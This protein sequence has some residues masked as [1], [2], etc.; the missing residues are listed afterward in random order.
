MMV[1][2]ADGVK[3]FIGEDDDELNRMVEPCSSIKKGCNKKDV[4]KRRKKK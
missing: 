2:D 4:A 3:I 1:Y